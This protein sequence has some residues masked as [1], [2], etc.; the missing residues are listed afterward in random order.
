[1]GWAKALGPTGGEGIPR[2]FNEISVRGFG[3][4]FKYFC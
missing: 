2:L 4:N 1:M 3:G